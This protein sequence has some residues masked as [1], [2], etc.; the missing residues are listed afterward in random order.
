[1]GGWRPPPD[2]SHGVV[3]L[4]DPAFP[5]DGFCA[6]LAQARPGEAV[7][8]GLATG[9]DPRAGARLLLDDAVHDGR[10]VGVSFGGG[11]AVRWLLSQGCRP[12]GEPYVVTR[13][14]RNVIAELAGRPPVER[15]RSLYAD[16]S[17]RDRA[18]LRDG[19]HL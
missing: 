7:S 12:I 17:E 8:G 4:A 15:L 19:L 10:A 9:L 18:L 2:D 6:W 11:V 5:A 3:L 14:Q 13:A 16:A 1:D